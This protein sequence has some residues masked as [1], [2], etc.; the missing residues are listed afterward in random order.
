MGESIDTVVYW[1]TDLAAVNYYN[2]SDIWVLKWIKPLMEQWIY[3]KLT[4]SCVSYS[5]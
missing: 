1:I 5:W 2:D 3:L 4:A